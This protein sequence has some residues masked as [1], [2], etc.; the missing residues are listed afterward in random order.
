MASSPGRVIAA[1][2][3][4][5][6]VN[7]IPSDISAGATIAPVKERIDTSGAAAALLR[8]QQVSAQ[9]AGGQGDHGNGFTSLAQET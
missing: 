7:I 4:T 1:R 6:V 9:V 2:K 3:A 8:T 5:I